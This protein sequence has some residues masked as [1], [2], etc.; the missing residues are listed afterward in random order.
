MALS[1]GRGIATAHDIRDAVV[2]ERRGGMTQTEGEPMTRESYVYI[3]TN[4]SN[5]V[6]YTGVTSD[7]RKRVW[8]HKE[9]VTGGFTQRFNVKKLVYVEVYTDIRDAIARE[10]QIKAGSR[11]KKIA[12]VESMNPE[13]RDLS[14]D[15]Q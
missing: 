11:A 9:G 7:L 10:K 6:L 14:E 1:A 13:W 5:R 12:L 15:L 4:K 8:Q 3:M 2:C